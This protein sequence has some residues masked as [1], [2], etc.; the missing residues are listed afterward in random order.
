MQRILIGP[1]ARSTI[2]SLTAVMEAFVRNCVS[3]GIDRDVAAFRRSALEDGKALRDRIFEFEPL[4]DRLRTLG[5]TAPISAMVHVGGPA[6]RDLGYSPRVFQ[7]R[8]RPLISFV[9]VVRAAF[10]CVAG[11]GTGNP[12]QRRQARGVSK[13]WS[14]RTRRPCATIRA[15]RVVAYASAP[16]EL[17]RA[18]RRE[19]R[20]RNG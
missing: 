12:D 15:P 8:S 3:M 2:A 6:A 18:S 13:G 10:Q 9:L 20:P 16:L 4:L 17:R 19:G 7:D 5:R 1:I 11:T 14:T